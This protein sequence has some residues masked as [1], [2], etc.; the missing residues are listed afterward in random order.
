MIY[1]VFI[2]HKPALHFNTKDGGGEIHVGASKQSQN[3]P[4]MKRGF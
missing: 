2:Y 3:I 4:A 1:P